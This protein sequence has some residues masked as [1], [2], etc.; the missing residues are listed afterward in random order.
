MEAK[1]RTV[2]STIQIFDR[3]RKKF[4][5]LTPEEWVRQHFATNLVNAYAVPES[6]LLLESEVSYGSVKKRPDLAVVGNNGETWLLAEFKSTDVDLDESV[7]QQACT[8]ASV[9][10][11]KF[12]ILSNGLQHIYA[13][14]KPEIG[15]FVYIKDLPKHSLN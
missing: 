2:D 9:L 7:W 3:F 8:Y 6:R 1:V 11:P 14:F 4:V 5:P 10:H 13:Q 12:M 15:N